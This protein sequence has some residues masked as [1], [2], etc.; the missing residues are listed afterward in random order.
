MR[1]AYWREAVRPRVPCESTRAGTE[2]AFLA[3]RARIDDLQL[4]Y[5]IAAAK[6][7]EAAALVAPFDT[8]QQWGLLFDQA[9][10]LFKQ[11]D[12]F[13]DNAA[14]AEAID[15]YR[16]CLALAPRSERP[17]DWARTQN[18]LGNALKALGGRESGTAR[19]EE[20]VAAFREA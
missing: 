18:N 15:V 9:G 19:L 20:A 1:I 12:E 14:L 17:V 11:G 10:E 5:R 13:G 3:Q 7:A 2:A 16:R 8:E 6:Y 4:S